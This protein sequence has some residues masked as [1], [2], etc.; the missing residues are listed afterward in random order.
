MHRHFEQGDDIVQHQISMLDILTLQETI[1]LKLGCAMNL[2]SQTQGS[3][4]LF[5][6][7]FLDLSR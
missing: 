1:E 2:N 3:Q 7:G 6:T 4:L 5:K